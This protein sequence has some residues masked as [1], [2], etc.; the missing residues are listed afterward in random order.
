MP[1]TVIVGG[2]YGSEGKG[3]V[4]AHLALADDA[5]FVVRCGGPNSGHT[6]DVEGRIFEL[7]Q[8][9]AGFVNRRSR[10]LIAPGA[11][12]DPSLLLHEIQLCGLTSEQIGVDLNAGVIESLDRAQESENQLRERLGSTGVGMGSAVSRRTLRRKDFRTAAD[13]PEIRP[14][15]TS[16]RE[17]LGPAIRQDAVVLVE[18]TQ[19]FGLSLY[20]TEEWP[21]CTSRDTTAH[22]F[23]GEVGVGVRNFDVVMAVRT[24]PIRV[25]GHSGPLKNEV[26]WDDV[27]ERSGYPVPLAEYTTTTKR[28][29]RV[30]EFDWDLVLRAVAANHPSHLALHG[31]DYI[32]YENRG[33]QSPDRLTSSAKSFMAQLALRTGV[34]VSF[35]GTGPL[36]HE[37]LDLRRANRATGPREIRAARA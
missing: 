28:L 13:V 27:T 5:D 25:G 30:A 2:Q 29:R 32:D 21:F 10:L 18:G 7:K 17:E 19:G 14:F 4:V 8:V 22:S 15:L 24:Y 6:V 1:V 20:H 34:P 26:S 12:I 33:V 23:L 37:L 16:V 9:P 11:M 31:L 3:K 35:A 36:V